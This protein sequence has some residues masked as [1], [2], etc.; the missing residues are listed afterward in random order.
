[1][2]TDQGAT[3]LPSAENP[4][5]HGHPCR[6]CGRGTSPRSPTCIAC[7]ALCLVS[8]KFAGW[9]CDQ[10]GMGVRIGWRQV[11]PSG[12]SVPLVFPGRTA[13]GTVSRHPKPV[14]CLQVMK[15]SGGPSPLDMSQPFRDNPYFSCS[16]VHGTQNR[17]MK[18]QRQVVHFG[19]AFAGHIPHAAIY[20]QMP[21][22]AQ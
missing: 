7:P 21:R 22:A 19:A 20:P 18:C 3:G 8:G 11:S 10:S 16:G 15:R 4:P 5:R 9:I 6:S 12:T 1:M 14:T 17:P 13:T 2:R